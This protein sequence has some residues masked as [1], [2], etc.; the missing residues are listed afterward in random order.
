MGRE[1]SIYGGK[2]NCI[3]STGGETY[4]GTYC[5]WHGE[6]EM[7]LQ[8]IPNHNCGTEGAQHTKNESTVHYVWSFV[9]M[10]TLMHV[11]STSPSS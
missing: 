7:H 8:D 2:E 10:K 5:I 9:N 11:S 3:P 6:T 1:C 4:C